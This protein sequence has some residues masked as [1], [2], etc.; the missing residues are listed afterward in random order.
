MITRDEPELNHAPTTVLE[1][2]EAGKEINLPPLR[3][4]ERECDDAVATTANREEPKHAVK[5]PPRLV[6]A[7]I[8]TFRVITMRTETDRG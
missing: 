5:P 6:K 2:H 7:C 4:L 8:M 3:K 1:R